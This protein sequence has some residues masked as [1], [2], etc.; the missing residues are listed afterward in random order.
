M[1][2]ILLAKHDASTSSHHIRL[3][4]VVPSNKIPSFLPNS[5]ADEQLTYTE[6]EQNEMNG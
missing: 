2:R 3:Q 1:L 4:M 6:H 5:S